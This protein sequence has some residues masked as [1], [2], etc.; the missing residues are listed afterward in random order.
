MAK[1]FGGKIELD[2]RDSTPDWSPY[3]A[4][5]APEGAP[6]VLI[7]LYDHTGL[8]AWSPFGGRIEMPTMD[9]LAENGLTYGQ[10]HTTA[11]CGPTRSCILTGRNHHQNSFATI[12]RDGHRVPRQQHAHPDGE[13]LPGRGLR[14]L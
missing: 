13:R 7:V 1:R 4:G 9:R 3:L 10:W 14:R 6:N 11:L 8:A 2:I 5:K 12:R